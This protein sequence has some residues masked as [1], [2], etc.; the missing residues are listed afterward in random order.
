MPSSLWRGVPVLGTIDEFWTALVAS[1]EMDGLGMVRG[2]TR[3][4]IVL[5]RAVPGAVSRD[6]TFIR[7]CEPG[8]PAWVSWRSASF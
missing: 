8:R 2:G 4:W 3:H 5:E 7:P 1:S 6:H